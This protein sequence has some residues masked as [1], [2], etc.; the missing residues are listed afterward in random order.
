MLRTKPD[1][2]ATTT[3]LTLP[4]TMGTIRDMTHT[5]IRKGVM[6]CGGYGTRLRPATYIYNKHLALVYD[7]PM[8]LFPLATLRSMGIE[9]ILLVSGGGHVGLFEEFLGDG[10]AYEVRMTYKVQ[11]EAGGIAQALLLAEDFVG[12]E[13]FAVI[14]GDNYYEHIIAAP[15]CCGIVVKEVEH[16]ERFGVLQNGRIIEKPTNPTSKSAVTGLYF[17]TQEVF[18]FIKT[19]QPSA[20]G[21]L[22]ITDVNNF[23]LEHLDTEIVT[24]EGFW[25]DMGTPDSL[26]TTA[27]F[28]AN[29]SARSATGGGAGI[30][31]IIQGSANGGD[32]GFYKPL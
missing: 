19:L 12:D 16:P 9:E 28:I 6:L 2:R 26:L 4:H 20:R 1:A 14:L 22:E 21:E 27:N 23:C 13:R 31:D 7:R 5:R 8:V 29:P 10:S 30:T 24:Y 3:A 18:D 11:K 32:G 15:P 25:S 17:Y